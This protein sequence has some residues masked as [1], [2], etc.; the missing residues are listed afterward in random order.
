[1]SVATYIYTNLK[2]LVDL[3]DRIVHIGDA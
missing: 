1:M 3:I 2:Y